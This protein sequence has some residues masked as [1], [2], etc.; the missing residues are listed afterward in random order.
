MNEITLVDC[1]ER[2]WTQ[3]W[4][5]FPGLWD[6]HPLSDIRRV[7]CTQYVDETLFTEREAALIAAELSRRLPQIRFFETVRVPFDSP[8]LRLAELA[9]T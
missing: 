7:V 2:M 8:R 9:L 3:T 1:V 5:K 4:S 6:Q